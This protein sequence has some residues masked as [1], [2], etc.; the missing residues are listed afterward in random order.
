[1]EKT[2]SNY[3]IS[4]A[5]QIMDCSEFCDCV[6]QTNRLRR[7]IMYYLEDELYDNKQY[8]QYFTHLVVIE[9]RALLQEELGQ[10]EFKVR[11]VFL[12]KVGQRGE[13]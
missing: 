2:V 12:Y 13:K 6:K 3:F 11:I 10:L 4:K 5:F 9:I 8:S 1:M 7:Q